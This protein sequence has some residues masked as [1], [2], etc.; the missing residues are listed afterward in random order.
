MN[1]R[2]PDPPMHAVKTGDGPPFILVHGAFS[3]LRVWGPQLEAL[4]T[5]YSVISVSLRGYH[6]TQSMIGGASAERHVEDLAGLIHC[7]PEPVVLAGHSRG[8]RVALEA[9]ARCG[10]RVAKLVL[11]EPGGVMEPGFLG[12]AGS[13]A[14]QTGP[15]IRREAQRLIAAGS[16]A[17]GLEAYIDF[18]H[19]AGT[20]KRLPAWFQAMA[21]DNAHTIDMMIADTS[22]PISRQRARMVTADTLMMA[23]SK[24]PRVFHQTIDVLKTVLPSNSV[25]TIDDGDHFMSLLK[26]AEVNEAIGVFLDRGTR[27]EP[28]PG[29]SGIP[30]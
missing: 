27:S 18:G 23:G 15:D 26:A 6:P 2:T 4:S 29:P 16:P 12:P 3:D 14:G 19:G 20:W 22:V 17:A 25:V 24:S 13:A 1:A 5:A 21:I 30:P 28:A 8:G 11:V 9:A 7:L 10:D